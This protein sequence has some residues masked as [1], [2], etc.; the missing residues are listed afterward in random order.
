MADS[1]LLR[2]RLRPEF[3]THPGKISGIGLN[4]P[5]AS[6]VTDPCSVSGLSAREI[7]EKGGCSF[8]KHIFKPR[9]FKHYR[10]QYTNIHS[11]RTA[12]NT[13]FD[14]PGGYISN[15][16]KV[17]TSCTP[18]DG[19]EPHG[20]NIHNAEV[21]TS[22]YDNNKGGECNYTQRAALNLVRNTRYTCKEEGPNGNVKYSHTTSEYLRNKCKSFAQN[23]SFRYNH[24]LS[25]SP[26]EYNMT[27]CIAKGDCVAKSTYKPI[28]A[29]SSSSRIASLKY[30]N[31]PRIGN[32]TKNC[33][34]EC[35][36][37]VATPSVKCGDSGM[38]CYVNKNSK[39]LYRRSWMAVYK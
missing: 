39:S 34:G 38:M 15:P 3:T 18:A 22:G 31:H 17:E 12:T 7:R 33:P 37:A 1:Y 29:T 11:N 36:V 24:D 35:V 16:A 4:E 10:R 30:Q 27:N 9:P 13:Q 20:I 8:K 19:S 2:S 26:H 28:G 21:T 14:L 6:S 5:T 32:F 23:A 25:N